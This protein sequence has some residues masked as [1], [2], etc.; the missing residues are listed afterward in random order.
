MNILQIQALAKVYRCEIETDHYAGFTDFAQVTVT[1]G[2]Q[3]QQIGSLLSVSAMSR[4]E[5]QRIFES[6]SGV[7]LREWWTGSEAK[8]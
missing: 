7:S 4:E 8:R 2:D 5:L 3:R 1:K 6:V